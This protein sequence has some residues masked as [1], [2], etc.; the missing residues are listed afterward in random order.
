MLLLKLKNLAKTRASFI[1]QSQSVVV[2][3]KNS[4]YSCSNGGLGTP[5]VPRRT[6]T[7][8]EVGRGGGFNSFVAGNLEK[9]AIVVSYKEWFK[10]HDNALLDQIFTILRS[11]DDQVDVSSRLAVDV[12]LSQLGL[13]LS[14]AFVLEVLRYGYR[15]VDVLSCLKFFDWAGRQCGFHHTRATFYSIFKIMS[16]E[17]RMSL[18]LDFLGNCSKP[19]YAHSIRFYDTLVMGYAVAGKPETALQLFGKMRFLGLDLDSFA[20]HVLLNALVEGS[21]F[22]AVQVIFKQISLRGFEDEVTQAVMTKSFCKQK[23]LDKAEA[24]LRELAANGRHL[25]GHALGLLVD[26]LCKRNKFEHASSL[27]EEFHDSQMVLIEHAYDVWI[28]GLVKAGKLDRAL[29]FFKTKKSLDGYI[30]DVFRYNMLICRLLR[31]SRLSE[32]FDLLMEMMECQIS[33]DKVTM[34]AALCFFCKAGMVNVALDLYNARSEFGLT[35]NSMAYNYLINTLCGH[36]SS[37]E[38]FQVLKNSIDQGFFPG[39]R[40]FSILADAFCREGNFDKMKELM[41]V[42]FERKLDDSVYSKFISAL[43]RAERIENGYLVPGKLNKKVTMRNSFFQLNGFKGSNRGDIAARLLVEMQK[44]G[45]MPTRYLFRDVIR[46]ICGMDNPEKKFGEL[47]SMQF[48]NDKPKKDIYNFFIDGA[49]HAQKPDLARKVY[50]L[51]LESEIEPCLSSDILMLQSYLKS[52]R[53]SDALKFFNELRK[54]RKVGRKLYNTLVVGLCNANRADTALEFMN[55]M[56]E[57][58]IVP[59]IECFEVLIKL[60]CSDQRYD[61]AVNLINDYEKTGRKLT[62]FIGNVL[63]FHSLETSE[64]YKA[65]V[66]SKEVMDETSGSSTLG[67]L[68][69]AFSGRVS[70]TGSVDNL[71]EVIERCFPPDVYTYNLL[72]SRRVSDRDHAFELFK[73]MLQKGYEPNHWTEKMLMHQPF[74]LEQ[75]REAMRLLEEKLR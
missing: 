17:K 61:A 47:L 15:K 16:R 52:Y 57:N 18:M 25:S 37:D 55:E 29:E 33:P 62:S 27:I 21:Y 24:Y 39:K 9:D 43:C 58:N 38:A 12:G 46:C 48:F 54:R 8:F 7:T 59:S 74:S 3:D 11:A 53:I 2:A 10:S 20:Y 31:E 63:L 66:R 40:A 65:W 67:L 41:M 50:E 6:T 44:K 19:T 60:L 70:M 75:K 32:V 36:G 28:R 30:P 42:A 72:V 71:E 35:L 73:R 56:K 14:E 4:F 45:H 64:L 68:I 5:C 23:Q 51:M 1:P 22:D 49:G 69:G 26:G 34:N 13:R